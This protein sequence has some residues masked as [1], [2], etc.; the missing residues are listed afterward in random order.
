MP[1]PRQRPR[2]RYRRGLMT[3]TVNNSSAFGFS[4]M[5]TSSFGMLSHLHGSPLAPDVALFALGAVLAVSAIEA[6]VSRGF[7]RRPHT[8]PS[9]VVLLGTAGNLVS[10][11]TAIGIVYGVG[12]TL[13]SSIVWLLAPLLAA[14]TYVLVEGAELALAER[15]EASVF[16]ESEAESP[17]LPVGRLP[18][19]P[20]GKWAAK[21]EQ[22]ASTE[23]PVNARRR[24]EEVPPA[25]PAAASS[26][27]P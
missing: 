25:L 13:P 17:E 24:T 22:R 3:S 14:A 19:P 9:N 10:V 23:V 5:I 6:A 16:G 1:E 20:R 2:R 15:L 12:V 21:C 26:G 27:T 4:V 11:A 7:R 18:R 8:H